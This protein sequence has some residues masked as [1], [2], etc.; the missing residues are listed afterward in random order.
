M[1]SLTTNAQKIFPEAIGFGT[2]S[3]GAYGDSIAPVVLTVNSLSASS[4]Q[5]GTYSGSFEWCCTRDYPRIIVFS[6]SG[7]IDYTQTNSNHINIANPYINI[8]GQTALG[9]GITLLG[10]ELYVN[11]HDVLIQHLKVRQSEHIYALKEYRCIGILNNASNVVVDHCSF[12]FANDEI[13]TIWKADKDITVSNC[14]IAYPLVESTHMEGTAPALHGF[15]TLDNANSNI[16]YIGNIVAFGINRHPIT[17]NTK[18]LLLNNFHYA[19]RQNNVAGPTINNGRGRMQEYIIK[20]NKF[21]HSS[22]ASWTWYAGQIQSSVL[23]ESKIYFEDNISN[24]SLNNPLFSEEQCVT[25]ASNCVLQT[26]CPFDTID[27]PSLTSTANVENYVYANAGAFYWN[28]DYIDEVVIANLKAR[29]NKFINSPAPMAAR[30]YDFGGKIG[31]DMSAGYNFQSNNVMFTVN[32][33]TVLLTKDMKTQA[34]V[35]EAISEQLPV[36]FEIIDHPHKNCAYLILQSKATGSTASI[37]IE[38]DATVLG[39]ANGIYYG[40]DGIGGYPNFSPA[41]HDLS[42]DLNMPKSSVT[43]SDSDGYTDLEEWV[44]DMNWLRSNKSQL[45]TSSEN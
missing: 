37:T 2:N 16:A 36:G 11:T 1:V 29:D 40:T 27:F 9:N 13:V 43:D 23:P 33:D 8:Y 30:V 24:M 4:E 39:F 12:T 14:I 3:R 25:N 32:G 42:S 38:G 35:I 34:E 18:C 28:R 44:H 6:V 10:C 7:V 31:G 41:T 22:T 20:G 17:D 19:V 26:T 45:P 5:T 15:C 21:I